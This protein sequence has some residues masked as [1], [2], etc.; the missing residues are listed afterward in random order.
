LSETSLEYKCLDAFTATE[1]NTNLA[2]WQQYWWLISGKFSETNSISII[3]VLY[4]FWHPDY[5]DSQPVW[6]VIWVGWMQGCIR[7]TMVE[8]ESDSETSVDFNHLTWL[9]AWEDFAEYMLGVVLRS[10]FYIRNILLWKWIETVISVLRNCK[11]N[12][13]MENFCH[14][15]KASDLKHSS[16]CRV[17]L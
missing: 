13:W 17:V 15:T 3:M 16:I 8:T 4:D 14:Y 2:R 7:T 1:F 11:I 5:C 6:Y 12:M 10:S 9:S